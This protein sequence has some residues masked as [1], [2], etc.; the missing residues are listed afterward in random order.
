MEEECILKKVSRMVEAAEQSFLEQARA[1]P[2]PWEGNSFTA[3]VLGT[4][5]GQSQLEP[6]MRF[7]QVAPKPSILQKRPKAVA[8]HPEFQGK[9]RRLVVQLAMEEKDDG[10]AA[11]IVKW[12]AILEVNLAASQVGRQIVR[13]HGKE[14]EAKK[15]TELLYDVL[16]RKATNTLVARATAMLLFVRWSS[17][18]SSKKT[19]LPID[20]DDLYEYFQTIRREMKPATRASS[21]MEAWAFC[22]G[23]LGY[24]DTNEV[25]LSRRCLGAAHRLAL[26]KKPRNRA[27]QD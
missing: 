9:R 6:A 7:S 12:S 10:R 3:T 24:E 22:V 5:P 19:A 20:E 21:L 23:A 25:L 17:D 18:G 27:V 2:L 8:Y 14:Q 15:I 16:A 13:M 1:M 4:M 26:R 11:A